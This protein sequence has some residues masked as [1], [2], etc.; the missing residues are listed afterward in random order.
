MTRTPSWSLAW[1]F[2]RLAFAAL[3]VAAVVAQLI[4]TVSIALD[5]STPHGGHLGTV[6]ANFFSFFTIQSNIAA[7][8][9]LIAAAV[10]ALSHRRADAV[11]PRWLAVLLVC[12]T[13]Y[14]LVTGIVYNTLLRGIALPQ[15]QTVPWSNEVLHV[16]IPAFVLLDVLLAPI[17]RRVGWTAIGIVIVYPIVWAVYTLIR[18]N[19]VVNPGNGNPWWYPYPFLDPHQPGGYG[20]VAIYV[21]VIAAAIGACS[22]AVIAI[23][24]WR[25]RRT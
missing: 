22:V 19:L 15:G 12:V 14:M 3:G 11:E 17:R 4:R 20:T 25:A 7:A 2:V 16:V 8:I 18:A 6:I 9:A 10:W 23:G 5:A 13:T 1:A 24:R 21:V